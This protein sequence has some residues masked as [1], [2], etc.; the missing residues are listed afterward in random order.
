MHKTKSE[1]CPSKRKDQDVWQSKVK[2]VVKLREREIESSQLDCGVQSKL[3]C[4][5]SWRVRKFSESTLQT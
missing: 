4:W 1:H 5:L 3:I 2:M